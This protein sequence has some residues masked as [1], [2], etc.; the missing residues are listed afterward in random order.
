MRIADT[1][2]TRGVSTSY[3]LPATRYPLPATGYP[4]PAFAAIQVQ[5]AIP[6][7]A[8]LLRLTYFG[9]VIARTGTRLSR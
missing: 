5:P 6:V 8:R 1:A 7:T 4:L 3:R 9:I 2:G